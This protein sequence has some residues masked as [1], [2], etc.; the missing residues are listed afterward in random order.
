MLALGFACGEP[1]GA[2]QTIDG[3][4]V[5]KRPA[6]TANQTGIKHKIPSTVQ[7]RNLEIELFSGE[8]AKWS[9]ASEEGFIE[10]PGSKR[11]NWKNLRADLASAS[12]RVH[13]G[14]PA[15]K[16]GK[17]VA[18][19]SIAGVPAKDQSKIFSIDFGK[20][21]PG[22][23]PTKNYDYYVQIIGKT[24]SGGEVGASSSLL[25]RY[26]KPNQD[27]TRFTNE[28][29]ELDV[30][31]MN[32][33][34]Y[35]NSPMPVEIRL[36]TLAVGRPNEDGA[37]EPYLMVAAI[38]VDGTSINVL[39][40]KSSSVR[41]FKSSGAHGNVPEVKR[42]GTVKIPATTG[43]F[44]FSI[45]LLGKGFLADVPDP[46]G[47]M[48]RI[49]REQTKVY[50]LV[51]AMEEDNATDAAANEARKAFFEQLQIELDEIVQSIVLA[52][53]QAGKPP[54]FDVGEITKRVQE[55]AIDAAL[56]K[57]LDPANGWWTPVFLPVT[58]LMQAANPDDFVGATI[59]E[60]SFGK[61]LDSWPNK[62][63]F[64]MTL[65]RGG[66]KDALYTVKGSARRDVAR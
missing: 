38:A 22:Y 36:E 59:V 64:S 50:L 62:V 56:N 31:G 12:W 54:E 41:M 48:G 49:V 51:V 18:E 35:A 53:L 20:F 16:G 60:I 63:E 47:A 52:D 24:A 55:A 61:L 26:H 57:S 34:L 6:A 46:G 4:L 42:Y 58:T 9:S 40:F 21:L 27:G 11:L 32:K 30:K 44:K 17:L 45:D 15:D 33:D 1:A 10:T 19:G 2:G 25:V 5:K 7:V 28:G 23:P 29:L 39:N 14:A 13:E 8:F 66:S 65:T 43:H 3:G 37:D